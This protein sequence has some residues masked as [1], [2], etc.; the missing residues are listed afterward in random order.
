MGGKKFAKDRVIGFAPETVA[1]LKMPNRDTAKVRIKTRV[2]QLL[3]F[4]H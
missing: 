1:A 3:F 4:I 2:I